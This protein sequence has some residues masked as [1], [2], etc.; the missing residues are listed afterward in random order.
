MSDNFKL[1]T[2]IENFIADNCAFK[3][4]EPFIIKYIKESGNPQGLPKVQDN[5]N[6]IQCI[7]NIPKEKEVILQYNQNPNGIAINIIN[8]SFEFVLYKN[9]SNP[10][11]IK[12]LLLLI[13]NDIEKCD[14]QE[15][16]IKS[17]KNISDINN[18]YQLLEKLKKFIFN[19]IKKN[20]KKK[21]NSSDDT[22]NNDLET[23][24]LAGAKNDLRF[25][26]CVN[27]G[28][29]YEDENIQKIIKIIKSIS[30]KLEIKQKKSEK[31]KNEN[32]KNEN[33]DNKDDNKDN[34]ENNEKTENDTKNKT[35]EKKF[36]DINILNKDQEK[37]NKLKNRLI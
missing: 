14:T 18:E 3:N 22:P 10:S 12:C 29:N 23:I 27:N 17:D 35:Y 36:G 19:Y 30:S 21:K 25:F 16:E 6:C 4:N 9:D 11:L 34:N 31:E 7:M 28:I 13:I 33:E 1:Y 26:N 24:L 15:V 37:E 32:K 2:A 5:K 8:S 20:R